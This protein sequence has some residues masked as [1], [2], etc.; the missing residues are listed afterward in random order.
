[1]ADIF[2]IALSGLNASR[3]RMLTAANNLANL[4][5]PGYKAQ[6]ADSA[7]L[8]GG[9]GA[10]TDSVSFSPQAGALVPTGDPLDL[11]IA[12]EGYFQ[13]ADGTGGVAYARDGSFRP[14][15]NGTLVNSQGMPLS[16][17]ITVPPNAARV[18]IGED[19]TVTANMADGTTAN[20]GQIQLTRF[21]NPGG[22]SRQGGNLLTPTP[23]AGTP[24]SGAP[25]TAGRG[26]ILS[27]YLESS[28]VNI[29][30]EVITLLNEENMTKA[31]AAVVRTADAMQKTLLDVKA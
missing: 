8:P 15:S 10:A 12:G 27:G 2:S 11:A 18:S 24:Q 14:D 28:N 31:N 1:M 6:R 26:A 29:A 30:E 20:L 22:L 23:A 13:V 9:N 21:N 25:G 3:N 5:T 17:A 4:N 7:A 19:G 16:P